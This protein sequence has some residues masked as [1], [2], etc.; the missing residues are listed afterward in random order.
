MTRWHVRA[1]DLQDIVG[2]PV[3]VF[4]EEDNMWYLGQIRSVER[5]RQNKMSSVK[6]F[7]NTGEEEIL[8]VLARGTDMFVGLVDPRCRNA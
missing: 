6:I 7:Y 8:R 1:M 2:R 5:Y 4:W 3:E